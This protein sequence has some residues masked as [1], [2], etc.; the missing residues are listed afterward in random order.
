LVK[1]IDVMILVSEHS[2]FK[3]SL[4]MIL[5]HGI[6]HGESGTKII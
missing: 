6:A 3:K 2:V 4:E 1:Q 5:D